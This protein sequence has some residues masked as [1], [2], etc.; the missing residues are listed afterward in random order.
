MNRPVSSRKERFAPPDERRRQLIAATIDV[1]ADK[2]LSRLTI[3]DVTGR[4][5]LSMGIVNHHFESKDY[6]LEATLTHLAESVRD[7]WLPGY[8][9][10][11]RTAADRLRAMIDGLFDPAICNR[12]HI[13]AWF[14]F[15]GDAHFRSVYRDIAARFD[16][17]R[18]SALS[19]LCRR[20]VADGGYHDVVPERLACS[21]ETM[22]DGLWLSILLYPDEM[23]QA[24]AV[25]E[26]IG[27]LARFLPQHF[28]TPTGLEITGKV[29]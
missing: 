15:F 17:E 7:A 4:A 18:E 2:G 25:R 14:S 24:R 3:S 29:Q 23:D 27:L 6:L 19:D 1:I 22:A 8:L 11:G 12:A 26:I 5:G 20:I 16:H 21:V 13:A 10:A 9:D 28:A